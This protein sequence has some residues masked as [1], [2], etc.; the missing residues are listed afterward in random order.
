M[1]SI[2]P[3]FKYVLSLLCMVLKGDFSS[4][5][6][7][8]YTTGSYFKAGIHLFHQEYLWIHR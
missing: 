4:L 7:P 1:I 3:L 2:L 6:M 8:G 5:N